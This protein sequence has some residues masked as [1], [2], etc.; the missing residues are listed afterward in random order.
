[1]NIEWTITELNRR[2]SDGFVYYGKWKVTASD[3]N[4]SAVSNGSCE[5]FGDVETPYENLT[6]ERV[7]GWVWG[8]I[9]KRK[10]EKSIVA[11][12]NESKKVAIAT[13]LPWKV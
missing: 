11:E 5:F 1:M 13:G 10:I 2:T 12:L 4:F 7:L 9:D 8:K 6:E 3:G